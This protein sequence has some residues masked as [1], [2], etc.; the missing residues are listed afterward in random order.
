M[1]LNLLVKCIMPH[2]DIRSK[3]S[4]NILYETEELSMSD[5]AVKVVIHSC[6]FLACDFA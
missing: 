6:V 1:M 4:V 3:K 2:T 5:G